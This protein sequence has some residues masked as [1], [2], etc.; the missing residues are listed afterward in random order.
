MKPKR[1]PKSGSDGILAGVEPA[2]RRAQE[3]ARETAA[4][5]RTPLVIYR[6]G[7]IE[8]RMVRRGKQSTMQN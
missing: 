8:K 4:R 5:T 6:N 7:K 3:R 1:R 2:L